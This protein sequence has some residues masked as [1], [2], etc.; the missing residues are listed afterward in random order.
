[1]HTNTHKMHRYNTFVSE[2]KIVNIVCVSVQK[3]MNKCEKHDV[4]T[5]RAIG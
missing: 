4:T 1:M 5:N 3:Y 2:F